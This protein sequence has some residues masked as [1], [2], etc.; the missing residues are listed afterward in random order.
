MDANLEKLLAGDT[1][2]WDRF[3]TRHAG[4]IHAAI[5]KRLRASGLRGE[6]SATLG[7][8]IAQEVFVRLCAKDFR[9]LRRYDPERASLVT[10]LTVL[11]TSTTLDALRRQRRWARTGTEGER[12]GALSLDDVPEPAAEPE[13]TE[14]PEPVEL[15][16]GLL[17]E[18]Q[19]LVLR[20]LYDRDMDV[21]E[22]AQALGV[23][24][25]TVRS[26]HHKAIEKLRVHHGVK[27][28]PG[29][30]KERG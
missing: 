21:A 18:R 2:A 8:D 1:R 10:F 24:E 20:M 4:V 7:E 14:T 23:E 6:D 13:P 28:P 15:P 16:E 3:V 17:S 30:S 11:S 27:K 12:G 22:V 5:W 26:T 9:L 19:T 25:Q 29:G